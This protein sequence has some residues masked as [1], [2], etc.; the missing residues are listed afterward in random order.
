MNRAE[1]IREVFCAEDRQPIVTLDW[2]KD[3][4]PIVGN[5]ENVRLL[6]L[7]GDSVSALVAQL[8]SEPQL[9]AACT[10][11]FELI[12]NTSYEFPFS[13]ITPLSDYLATSPGNPEILWGCSR[14]PEQ[15]EN[16]KLNIILTSQ[17]RH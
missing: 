4:A 7:T 11:A 16:L 2:E 15:P 3:I 1:E 5:G 8:K 10:I 13:D 9:S 17:N 14:E 6:S 12:V